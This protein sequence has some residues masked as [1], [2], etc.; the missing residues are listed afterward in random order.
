MEDEKLFVKHEYDFYSKEKFPAFGVIPIIIRR[1]EEGDWEFLIVRENNSK[2]GKKLSFAGS[3][4][5][6]ILK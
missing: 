2:K 1:R 6:R 5:G 3:E 4:T